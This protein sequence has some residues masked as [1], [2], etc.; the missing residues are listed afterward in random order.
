MVT[1]RPSQGESLQGKWGL[2]PLVF[3]ADRCIQ[4]ATRGNTFLIIVQIIRKLK[5][6]AS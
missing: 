5:R 3:F 2:E 1:G 4:S 6:F